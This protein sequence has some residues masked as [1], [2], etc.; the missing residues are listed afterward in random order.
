LLASALLFH[1]AWGQPISVVASAFGLVL[2]ATGFGVLLMSFIKETRQTGPILGGVLT[3]TS[4]IGGLMSNGLP[5]VP[6]VMNTVSLTMPQGW[7]MRA[8]QLC[9]AGSPPGALLVPVLVMI[10]LGV[11]FF[12][13]GL[14]L[15]R[16]R[17]A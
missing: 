14:S 17:F 10:A 16:R 11:V 7:A 8:M 6:P 13:V 12:L 9:L 4:M 5:N 1:I 15:F 3:V 2:C